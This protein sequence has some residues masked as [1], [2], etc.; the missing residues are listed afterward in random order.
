MI[1]SISKPKIPK[2]YSYVLKTSQLE[3]ILIQ[4]KI[5]IHVDLEYWLPQEIGTILEAYY[6]QP[7]S[8]VPYNRLYVRAGALPNKDVKGAKEAMVATVFPAFIKWLNFY[9]KLPDNAPQLNKDPYFDAVYKN[10][11]IT[12]IE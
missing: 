4:N 9:L 1:H 11:K 10:N 12:L 8:N 6:W 7:N 3:E 2:E 5:V